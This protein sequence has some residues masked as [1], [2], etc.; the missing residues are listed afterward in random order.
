MGFH[1]IFVG[2][3]HPT[4]LFWGSKSI[5]VRIVCALSRPL[6]SIQIFVK[7]NTRKH[8]RK[9]VCFFAVC[10]VFSHAR[11]AFPKIL[12]VKHTIYFERPKE[13]DSL[14][15]SLSSHF[16]DLSLLLLLGILTSHFWVVWPL[17]SGQFD[18]SLLGSLTIHFWAVWLLT[19]GQFKK[20]LKVHFSYWNSFTNCN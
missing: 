1:N 9:F 16:C 18:Y 10:V 5:L 11:I 17:T 7:N 19:S 6:F 3:I 4:G 20:Y 15:C 13:L 2:N 12:E 8:C 14:L